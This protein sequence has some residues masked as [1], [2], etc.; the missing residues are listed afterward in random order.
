MLLHRGE[1]SPVPTVERA[2]T[3]LEDEAQREKTTAGVLS[4]RPPRRR[5]IVGTPARVRAGIE[6]AA[7][8]Y[9]ADEVMVVTITH[10]HQAR[11]RSYELLAR[12]FALE[13]R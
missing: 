6:Q 11:R 3:F 12:E 13:S 1:L 10:N 9:G 4:F 2:L 5:R 8:E 7:T